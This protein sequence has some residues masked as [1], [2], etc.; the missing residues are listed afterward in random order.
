MLFNNFFSILIFLV[1]VVIKLNIVYNNCIYP[2]IKENISEIFVY[3]LLWILIYSSNLIC[4][5]NISFPEW[6]SSISLKK[7]WSLYCLNCK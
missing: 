6:Y 1:K 3:V 5:V 4:A 2:P 7:K